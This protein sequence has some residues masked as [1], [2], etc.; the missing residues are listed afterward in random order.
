MRIINQTHYRTDQLRPLLR[1]VAKRLALYP[2]ISITLSMFG[3]RSKV[4]TVSGRWTGPG[5]S[6]RRS[7]YITGVANYY[8]A[9][10]GKVHLWLPHRNVVAPDIAYAF[11]EL[12]GEQKR[13]V[14]GDSA[15][16]RA[17]WWSKFAWAFQYRI[18][19]QES[20]V[21]RKAKAS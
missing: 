15:E 10:G 4:T 5:W 16:R 1:Q 9:H 8:Q 17:L 2:P 7:A 21:G 13:T 19:K 11:H 18:E 12:C 3:P 20:N 14:A 6:T